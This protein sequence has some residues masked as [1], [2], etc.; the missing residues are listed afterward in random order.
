M[1]LPTLRKSEQRT[2]AVRSRMLEKLSR[3]GPYFE[4]GVC[5]DEANRADGRLPSI[6]L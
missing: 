2:K 5:D 6:V 1:R 4:G 3:A